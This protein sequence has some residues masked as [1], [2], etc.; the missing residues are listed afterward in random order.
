MLAVYVGF[1][2]FGGVLIVASLLGVGHDSD[3]HVDL[4]VDTGHGSGDGHD[5]SQASAWL[6]LGARQSLRG[7]NE[8]PEPTFGAFGSAAIGPDGN[9]EITLSDP[10]QGL[11]LAEGDSRITITDAAGRDRDYGFAHYFGLNDLFVLS[12]NRPISP[13][14]RPRNWTAAAS[15]FSRL[16]P[17]TEHSTSSINVSSCTRSDCDRRAASS[18]AG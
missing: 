6:S 10:D 18:S 17:Q 13:I 16:P 7:D 12:G 9:L 11:A 5:Q 4:H 3:V 8:P 1:L 14:V 2:L 15:S